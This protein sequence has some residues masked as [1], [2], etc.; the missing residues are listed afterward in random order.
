M[1][2]HYVRALCCQPA[3]HYVLFLSCMLYVLG[4]CLFM[5]GAADAGHT[6]D[7]VRYGAGEW[8][9]PIVMSMAFIGFLGLSEITQ[10]DPLQFLDEHRNITHEIWRL[11]WIALWGLGGGMLGISMAFFRWIDYSPDPTTSPPRGSTTAPPPGPHGFTPAY[12]LICCV[13]CMWAS[14]GFA[15]AGIMFLK[16]EQKVQKNQ[17]GLVNPDA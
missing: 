15:W 2:R 17:D 4:L 1:L 12:L 10:Q 14:L 8:F 9:V 16:Q 13:V 3:S 5:I 11:I 7:P 6:R